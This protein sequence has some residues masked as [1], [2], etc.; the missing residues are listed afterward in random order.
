MRSL[1]YITLALAIC[2]PLAGCG[3]TQKK[4]PVDD[5]AHEHEHEHEHVHGAHGGHVMELGPNHHA[6]WTHDDDSGKVQVYILGADQKT[7]MPIA[8]E[9]VT[10]KTKVGDATRDFEL[11]AV[12]PMEGKTALFELTDKELLTILNSIGEATSATLEV[13]IDGTIHVEKFVHDEHHH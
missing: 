12:N 11:E 6:E 1:A 13:P 3:D 9:K 4:K 2:L 10:I 5:H 7:E 8:A